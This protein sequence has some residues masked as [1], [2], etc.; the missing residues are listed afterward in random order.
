[1]INT[2]INSCHTLGQSTFVYTCRI[3]G[4]GGNCSV[5]DTI[6]TL[7]GGPAVIE[8]LTTI[9][10]NCGGV[11]PYPCKTLTTIVGNWG[12]V[13]FWDSK[14][15]THMVAKCGGMWSR[16]S[17]IVTHMVAKYRDGW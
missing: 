2:S 13:Q 8:T 11:T 14:T 9:E 7:G 3:R 6:N 12:G 10:G 5:S 16:V 1:M 17:K 4:G 15:L